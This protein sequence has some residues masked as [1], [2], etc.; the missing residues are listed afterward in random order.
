MNRHGW[1]PMKDLDEFLRQQRTHDESRPT[2]ERRESVRP[3]DWTPAVDISES[4]D[5]YL[6]EIELTGVNREAIEV[7]LRE[8]SLI[9]QGE[10]PVPEEPGRRYHRLERPRGH[11][12]R[13]FELPE[14]VEAAEIDG[15]VVEGVLRLSLPRHRNAPAQAA[16]ISIR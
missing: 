2:A 6:I 13:R 1:Y 11:F 14:N 3:A 10:R 15:E 12:L 8:G 16:R 7:T 9:I 5:G 4:A